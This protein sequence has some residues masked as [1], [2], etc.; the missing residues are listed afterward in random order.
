VTVIRMSR[1]QRNQLMKKRKQEKE[2]EKEKERK[3]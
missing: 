3:F 1:E 2:K